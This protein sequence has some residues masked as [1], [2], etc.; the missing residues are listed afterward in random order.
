MAKRPVRSAS[1]RTAGSLT[2]EAFDALS[3]VEKERIFQEIE[4][5][6]PEQRL[7]ESRPLNAR[8]K[9]RWNRIK[10]KIGEG[11]ASKDVKVISLSV[12]AS[13]LKRAD[14]YAKA[15]GLKRSELFSQGIERML[16]V[17]K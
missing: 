11:K 4:N 13:L 7:K 16:P 6:T 12:E 10:K 17:S 14:D 2:G 8:Q 3:E 9:A 5:G 1:L 15:I